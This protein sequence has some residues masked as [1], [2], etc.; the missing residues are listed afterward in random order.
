MA[1]FLVAY[2]GLILAR[3]HGDPLTFVKLS[4]TA[5]GSESHGYDGQYFYYLA[6][7]PRPSVVTPRLDVPAYRYQR[8][9]YPLLARSLALGLPALIPWTLVLVNLLTHVAGTWLVETW[10]AAHGVSRWYALIYGLW[11]GLLAS[12]RLDLA[13]PLCFALVTASF[14]VQLRGR[15]WL[16]AV[17]LGLALFAK[18]SA[19]VFL[20]A[21]FASACLGRRW[22]LAA[23][24]AAAAAPFAL[25]QL[26]LR[27]WFGS[28]GLAAGGWLA[29]PFEWLPFMGLWRVA[30]VSRAAFDLLAAILVPLVVA[31]AIWALVIAVGHAWQRDWDPTALALG[32]SAVLLA[33]APFSTF[34]EPLGIIRLATGLVLS[35]ILY[36]SRVGSRRALSYALIWISALALLVRD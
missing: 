20:A 29:T 1:V 23:R 13:E 34:S 22:G 7:D 4:D 35:T 32:A 31:P 26:L 9:L 6:L 27:Y 8:L 2:L 17:L 18:E 5:P 24:L 36:G 21:Q 28:F 11:A 30:W 16:A 10:L 14:V 3:A 25:F 33:V 19:L 12:V 15:Q